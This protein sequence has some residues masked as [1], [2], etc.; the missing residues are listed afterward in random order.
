LWNAYN[1]EQT[2]AT[3]L[4]DDFT[5]VEY[6]DHS[7][8]PHEKKS[9]PESPGATTLLGDLF[10]GVAN[11]PELLRT[12]LQAPLPPGKYRDAQTRAYRALQNYMAFINAEASGNL[13]NLDFIKEKEERLARAW[14]Y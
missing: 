14:A 2:H 1:P 8:E 9:T 7:E 11:S 5:Q 10:G 12:E 13:P 6:Y 4:Y 3:V